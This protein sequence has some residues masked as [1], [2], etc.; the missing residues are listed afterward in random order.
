MNTIVFYPARKNTLLN[1]LLIFLLATSIGCQKKEA[2]AIKPTTH[3]DKILNLNVLNPGFFIH[4][5][6]N[7]K[8]FIAGS[9]GKIILKNFSDPQW[10]AAN[11]PDFN[12]KITALAANDS[13]TTLV[14]V[15]EN[16][17]IALSDDSGLHWRKLPSPTTKTITALTFDSKHQRWIAAGEQG[18]FLHSDL[19]GNNWQQASFN[20]VST[21]SKILALPTQ[22][23]AI[24]ENGLIATSIDG[25]HEW[26][27]I[28]FISSA[29]LT[30]IIA[31]D[32]HVFIS[33]ADGNVMRGDLHGNEANNEESKRWTLIPTGFTHYLS[34]IFYHPQ[35]HLLISLSSEGEILLSDDGGNLWAPV[36]QNNKYLNDIEQSNDGNYLLAVGDHGQLLLSDN[37]G[38]TWSAAESP[39]NSNIEGI[40]AYGENGFIAYGEAGLLMQLTNINDKWKIINYPV[41]DFV[42]QLLADTPNNWFAVGAKGTILNSKDQGQSWRPINTDAQEADYFLSGVADKKS[43]NLI[44]AGPPGTILL[45]SKNTDKWQVR[46]ALSDS[47]QGYFHRLAT[48]NMGTVVAVAGPGITHYSTD[49]G[50]SWKPAT[51]DSSKQLF[52]VIYDQYHQQFI[53]VG[54]EGNI[55]ISTD[56]K[57]WNQI[58]T[59]IQQALQTVFATERRLWAAGDKG[60]LI[61]ST[62]AGKTWQDAEVGSSAVGTQSNASQS[63][64]LALFETQDGSLIASGAQGFIARLVV[65][66]RDAHWQL[67]ASPTQSSLRTPVQDTATGII[68][69]PGKT[70]EI[71]YSRDDGLH[72]ALLP[73]VTQGSL[74]NLYID[75]SNNTLIGVGERLILIPLLTRND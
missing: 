18:L 14:S 56:G 7:G 57:I 23:I 75:D 45:K 73:P 55:Q 64:I 54:Q 63:T 37:A 16:G 28:P 19:T 40:I 61:Q 66:E 68:Y 27:I 47:N 38:R 51:I 46:L 12:D 42:H 72:W 6:S 29:A 67:I 32:T 9:D 65:N 22:L 48:N 10:H 50:E 5:I 44:T 58:P 60:V 2:I 52:N 36:S 17:L 33:C 34:R 13:G 59:G 20:N 43:G 71:I 49:A 1:C 39:I 31:V 53:A 70:G 11:T 25:G 69:V 30:D 8:I 62:D 26:E 41:S 21:I 3:A 15:G 24:G 4:K 35:Q 74:K